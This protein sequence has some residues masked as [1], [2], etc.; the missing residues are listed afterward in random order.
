M[1]DGIGRVVTGRHRTAEHTLVIADL[2][3]DPQVVGQGI[4]LQL[5]A[6]EC[7]R[8]VGITVGVLVS[9]QADTAAASGIAQRNADAQRYAA[10]V[11]A[12]PTVLRQAQVVRGP[13]DTEAVA[14]LHRGITLG[15]VPV[16]G[17]GQVGVH[18]AIVAEL[19]RHVSGKAAFHMSAQIRGKCTAVIERFIDIGGERV[20]GAGVDRFVETVVTAG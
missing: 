5:R 4:V 19:L 20:V 18:A 10:N 15:Q 12:N 1:P 9:A 16:I 8:A 14:Q 3:V 13:T 11:I 2:L 7:G 6:A 17:L